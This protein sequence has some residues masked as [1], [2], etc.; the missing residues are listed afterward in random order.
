VALA[1]AYILNTG[2]MEDGMNHLHAIV[3]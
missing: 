3:K 2:T 1:D